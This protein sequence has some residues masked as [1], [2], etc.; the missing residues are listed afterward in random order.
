MERRFEQELEDLRLKVLEMASYAEQALDKALRSL[1]ERDTTL[2]QE[3]IDHDH[4]IN[5]L[6]CDIDDA[7]LKILALEQPVAVDLRLIVGS[8]RIIVNLERVGDEAVNI[9]ERTLLLAHRPALPFNHLLEEMAGICREMLK[10]A[11]KSFKDDDTELAQRVCD[12]DAR[13]NELDLS[14]IKKL[15]DYMLKE[16]PAIERS[17]H[18]ILASRS[19]ERIAD[20]S[21]NVAECVIFKV[22]GVDVKHHC[23]RF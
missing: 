1:I 13:A 15:I 7:S 9:A 11:I 14:M 17:V 8:M 21:T 2:A 3:V 5:Q 22:K 23:N 20:L 16:T 12:M 6:E 18:T 19:M 10:S 4:E